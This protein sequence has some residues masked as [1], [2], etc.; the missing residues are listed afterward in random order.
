MPT[1]TKPAFVV[2]DTP[3]SFAISENAEVRAQVARKGGELVADFRRYKRGRDGK[4]SHSTSGLSVTPAQLPEFERL[5][6]AA[7]DAFATGAAA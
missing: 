3:A 1:T 4:F 2:L 5:V 7:R 6:H